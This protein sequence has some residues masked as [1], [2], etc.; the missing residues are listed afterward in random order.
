M[1]MTT[2]GQ[3]LMASRVNQKEDSKTTVHGFEFFI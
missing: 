2:S 3:N 1:Q